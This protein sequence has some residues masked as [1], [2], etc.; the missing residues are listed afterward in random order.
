PRQSRLRGA[1]AGIS[2]VRRLWQG[3]LREGRGP[4]GPCHAGRSRRRD[5]LAG[6]GRH[7]RSQAGLPDRRFLRRLC[8][9]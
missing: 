5:G 3:V 7:D 1:P 2:R 6:Q 8:R 9:V 4:V